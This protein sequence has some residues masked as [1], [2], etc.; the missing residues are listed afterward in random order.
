MDSKKRD[1]T[2]RRELPYL[3]VNQFPS[4]HN[5]NVQLDGIHIQNL[6]HR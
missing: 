1:V 5:V 4:K 6:L 3:V 2:P